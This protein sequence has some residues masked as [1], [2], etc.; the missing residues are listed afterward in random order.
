M[1]ASEKRL[2]KLVDPEY[3][4]EYL[5]SMQTGWIV[6]QLRALREQRGWSQADLGRMTGKAQSAIGRLESE[7]YGNWSVGT[8][9]ELAKAFDVA[10]QIRFLSW[11]EFMEWTAD[12]SP[13]RMYV[14][15]YDP[16]AFKVTNAFARQA[17]TH[18]QSDY[19][20]WYLDNRS[21]IPRPATYGIASESPLRPLSAPAL[22]QQGL[23]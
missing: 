7:A 20:D 6:H 4:I 8:L 3:R 11:P 14:R 17:T 10:L 21:Q 12:T 15:G 13:S 23:N 19:G 9:Y 1:M 5:R 18:D 16:K 2:S 22:S